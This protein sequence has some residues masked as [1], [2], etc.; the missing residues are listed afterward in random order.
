VSDEDGLRYYALLSSF[1]LVT[2]S[3][4]AADI[5]NGSGPVPNQALT[6]ELILGRYFAATQ[7]QQGR[8]RGLKM[9]VDIQAQLPK[10]KKQG[11][12]HGFRKISRL[13]RVTYDALKFVGDKTIQ[14]EVIARYLTSEKQAE[15]QDPAMLAINE[16]N[17]KFK[18]KGLS[19]REHRSVH[20]FELKP[21][22][23]RLGLF[24]GELLVDAETYLPLREQ[25]QFVKNPSVFIKRIEFARDYT[26]QGGVAMPRHVESTVETRI[27]GKAQVSIDYFNIG[28]NDEEPAP[29]PAEAQ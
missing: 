15:E 24:K 8:L 10:L 16:A 19:E 20:V 26:I 1:V 2:L 28:R 12:L 4:G 6:P 14:N 3:L 21:R 29:V 5:Y 9:E 18:Y 7:G 11:R 17:Y 22:K 13:G 27:A 23:K 25:G